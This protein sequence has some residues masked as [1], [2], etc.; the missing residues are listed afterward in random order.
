[1]TNSVKAVGKINVEISLPQLLNYY[2]L[3]FFK[4]KTHANILAPD[5]IGWI[6]NK[7]DK[8]ESVTKTIDKFTFTMLI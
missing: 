8:F 7:I 4:R 2:I 3:T 1:M 5:L 6:Q